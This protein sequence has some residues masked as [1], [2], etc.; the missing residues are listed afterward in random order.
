[1]DLF[2]KAFQ[3][4]WFDARSVVSKVRKGGLPPLIW[5]DCQGRIYLPANIFS[6]V[7][8]GGLPP[9]ILER[10]SRKDLPAS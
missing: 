7:R 2:L 10:L 1:V 8:K 6:K 9:L 5:K 3:S 4:D